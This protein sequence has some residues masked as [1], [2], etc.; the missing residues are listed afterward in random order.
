MIRILHGTRG[1][2]GIHL[3]DP[4]LGCLDD[5]QIFGAKYFGQRALL[6]FLN[7]S[8]CRFLFGH[9]GTG[10]KSIALKNQPGLLCNDMVELDD[11]FVDYA[12][13]DKFQVIIVQ[14]DAAG[15]Q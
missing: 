5:F 15:C 3:I 7:W 11:V 14:H 9:A 4:F 13:L 10:M 1:V 8:L 6:S 2:R 12:G